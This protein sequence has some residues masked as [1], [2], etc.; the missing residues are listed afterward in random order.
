MIAG[1][2]AGVITPSDART[3]AISASGP[4]WVRMRRASSVADRSHGLPSTT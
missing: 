3:I 1:Q 4:S 2:L